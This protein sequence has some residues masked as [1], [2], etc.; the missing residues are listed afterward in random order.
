MVIASELRAGMA[1]RLEG[2]IYK[3][4]EAEFKAGSAKLDGVVKTKLSNV[5][6]GRLW[7]PHFRPQERLENLDIERRTLEFLFAD[8]ERSTF[9]DPDNFEQFEIPASLLGAAGGFLESGMMVPVEF[10]AGEPIGVLLPDVAEARVSSTAPAS[11]AQQDS[12]W[13]EAILENGI[14]VR[15]PLFI[16]PGDTIRLNVRDLRYL[17]RGKNERKRSA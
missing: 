9:M 7:E 6:S 3:V 1:L 10:Y 11:H 16:A 15:V 5:R 12:A 2:Q 8:Q 13:K 14:S 4:L 17:S